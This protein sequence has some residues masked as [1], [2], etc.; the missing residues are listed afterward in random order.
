[1]NYGVMIDDDEVAKF[2]N[3]VI[4]KA[5]DDYFMSPTLTKIKNI[6]NYSMYMSKLYCL[7]SKE[8]RYI[9]IF[10]NA[11][12]NPV[13]FN[14]KL[15]NLNWVSFQTRTIDAEEYSN[16]KFKSHSYDVI[17]QGELLADI[18]R[19]EIT[20]EASIY[21]CEKLN[22]TVTLLHTEKNTKEVYQSS[23]HVISALETFQTIVTF[24]EE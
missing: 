7:L 11:D 8:C 16:F 22:L 14:E 5:F 3:D 2:E 13:H 1:M 9:V 6:G 12:S 18:V 20:E 24:K 21:D 19:T 23:G 15:A 10:T 17:G 4:Y